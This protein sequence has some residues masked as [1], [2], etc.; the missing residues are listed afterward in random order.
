MDCL[1]L[2]T[3]NSFADK[4]IG[5]IALTQLFYEKNEVLMLAT[6]RISMDL[7]SSEKNV[8]ALALTALSEIATDDMCLNLAKDVQNCMVHGKLGFIKIP[9][10]S[11]RKPVWLQLELLGNVPKSLQSLFLICVR[12]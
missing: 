12:C 11:P 5:Y 6:N 2:I 1:K 9:I 10:M 7:Q 8:V 4:K 3:S